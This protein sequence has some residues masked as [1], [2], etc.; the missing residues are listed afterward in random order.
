MS[1]QALRHDAHTVN[2]LP[3]AHTMHSAISHNLLNDEEIEPKHT[4]SGPP[5]G[6]GEL[7]TNGN[8]TGH[9]T[10]YAPQAQRYICLAIS[11]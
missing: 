7:Y 6:A 2:I 8:G 11:S 4:R 3:S 5:T 9:Y 1:L 10:P